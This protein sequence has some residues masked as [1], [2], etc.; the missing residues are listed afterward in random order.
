MVDRLT[1]LHGLG[2]LI[3]SKTKS[4]L[5]MTVSAGSTVL[6]GRIVP[7]LNCTNAVIGRMGHEFE[8][9]LLIEEHRTW[10]SAGGHCGSLG[11][12]LVGAGVVGQKHS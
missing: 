11:R 4:T 12:S 7:Y 6:H 8:P 3:K 1:R 2:L 10:H 5:Q 9:I